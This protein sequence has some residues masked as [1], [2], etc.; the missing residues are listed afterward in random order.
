[1]PPDAATPT[2]PVI[3]ING[4]KVSELRKPGQFAAAMASLK[5]EDKGPFNGT[6][7]EMYERMKRQ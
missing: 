2:W 4:L 1:M 5:M 3:Y 7:D 6:L